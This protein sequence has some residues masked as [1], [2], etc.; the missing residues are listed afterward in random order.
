M[1]KFGEDDPDYKV[2]AANL[3]DL[4]E[5][6]SER[7]VDS[8]SLRFAVR[9]PESKAETFDISQRRELGLSAFLERHKSQGEHDSR[10]S[11]CERG[12]I[13]T[14]KFHL[15]EE[16]VVNVAQALAL[17]AATIYKDENQPPTLPRRIT[18]EEQEGAW[19]QKLL[20][21]D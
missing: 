11:L 9:Q 19:P 2:I 18:F 16:N 21:I 6:L 4:S 8:K 15:T 20:D 1:V 7:D 10:S 5:S 17:T 12:R 14:D 3:Y 13:G